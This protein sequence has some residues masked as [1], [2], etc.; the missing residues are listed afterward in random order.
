MIDHEIDR[1]KALL[2]DLFNNFNEVKK[3]M[4]FKVKHQKKYYEKN[5]VYMS[6]EYC[7]N[8]DCIFCPHYFEWRQAIQI[9]TTNGKKNIGKRLGRKITHKILKQIGKSN[10]Y[11]IFKE[12]EQEMTELQ[13]KRDFYAKNIQKIQRILRESQKYLNK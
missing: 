5:S 7:S 4:E 2:D 9:N 12:L 11:H 13:K 6:L 10:M 8:S 3:E 1:L